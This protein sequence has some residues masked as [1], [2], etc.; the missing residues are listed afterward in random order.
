MLFIIT[1]R[2][3]PIK[4]EM[5]SSFCTLTGAEAG[6]LSYSQNDLTDQGKVYKMD[7][8]T[9]RNGKEYLPLSIRG[10]E[11]GKPNPWKK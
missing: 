11:K 6:R 1:H 3:K 10:L 5:V 9:D 2:P 4:S 7:L 8:G